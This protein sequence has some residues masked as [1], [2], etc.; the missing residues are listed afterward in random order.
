M[1]LDGREVKGEHIQLVS[2]IS[3]LIVIKST[4]WKRNPQARQERQ[5][6]RAESCDSNVY[7]SE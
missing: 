2:S 3:T 6:T 1:H 7:T 5:R 4:G